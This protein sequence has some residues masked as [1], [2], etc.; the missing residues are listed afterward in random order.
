MENRLCCCGCNKKVATG[1]DFL[2]G[3]DQ[4]LRIKLEGLVSGLLNLERL[5]KVSKDFFEEKTSLIKLIKEL[6]II[7]LKVGGNNEK[8]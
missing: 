4:I 2:P 1:S 3:H 6:Q 8:I 7:F 5:V